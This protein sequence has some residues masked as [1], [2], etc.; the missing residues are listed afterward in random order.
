MTVEPEK[1]ALSNEYAAR[2]DIIRSLNATIFLQFI[3][4]KFMCKHRMQLRNTPMIITV[5]M[6]IRAS[7]IN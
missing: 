2:M 4:L 3:N 7:D 6:G 1:L 5:R